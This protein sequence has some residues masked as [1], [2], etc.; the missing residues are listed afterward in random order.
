M[1]VAVYVRVSTEEQRER[2]SIETQREF[3]SKFCDLHSL[4]VDEVYADD[5]FSGTIPIGKRPGARRLLDDAR[6]R[7]KLTRFSSSNW[8]GLAGARV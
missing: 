2:Q 4:I 7:G 6:R 5:G 8:T 3:A 1:P